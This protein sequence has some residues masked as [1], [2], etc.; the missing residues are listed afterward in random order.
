MTAEGTA[1]EDRLRDL[2]DALA[3]VRGGWDHVT[4]ADLAEVQR[5]VVGPVVV[6]ELRA[7]AKLP[8]RQKRGTFRDV[9][10][11]RAD[12]WEAGS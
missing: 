10:R 7:L 9:L 5:A 11:A 6:A 4:D 1:D 2:L 3:D 8:D 12:A